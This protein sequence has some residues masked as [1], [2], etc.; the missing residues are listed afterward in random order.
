MGPRSASQDTQPDALLTTS[1]KGWANV[2]KFASSGAFAAAVFVAAVSQTPAQSVA[3]APT[4]TPSPSPSPAGGLQQIGTVT[5]ADR[6][7]EPIGQDSKPTFVVTRANIDATG[8]RTVADAL[9]GVPGVDLFAYGPFG[10]Q[11]N[12]GVRGSSSN[13]TLV[14]V[15]GFPVSDPTTGSVQ[16]GQFSTINV[17]RIEVVESG[18]STLY[19]TSAAGGVINIITTVPRGA[20][21]EASAGSYGDRDFRAGIGTADVGFTYE[22]HVATNDYPYPTFA[23]APDATFPGG[24]RNPSYADMSAGRLN[25]NVPLADGFVIRG[26]ADASATDLGVPGSI[27]YISPAT[28]NTSYNSGLFEIERDFSN[29]RITLSVLGSQT[30]LAYLQPVDAGGEDDVYTGTSGASIKDVISGKLLDAT[31]GMDLTRSSG[32]FSFATSESYSGTL[33]PAYATGAAQSEVA[34]YVQLGASPFAGSRFTAGLRTENNTPAG[35]IL[36]PSFGGIIHSGMLRFSGNVGESFIV[37]TL[38]DLYYPGYS[39]PNL[40]PEKVQTADATVAY[41]GRQGT[42]SAG[43]FDRNGSNFIVFAPPFY[44]PENVQKASTAGVALTATSRPY[45]GMTVSASYTDLYLAIDQGT[46]NRLPQNPVGQTTLTLS[47]PFENTKFE[48]GFNWVVVGSDGDDA[49]N[50]SP[51]ETTYDAYSTLSA[52]V[53]YKLAPQAIVSVRGFNLGNQQYAP[54]FGY[55]APGRTVYV[56]LSTR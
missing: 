6:K 45:H 36:A 32:V 1:R 15:D 41:E 30:R 51:V 20:Y 38:S 39:N 8:A 52:Y 22:R 11:V 44:L 29:Q 53:R 40:L 5:T 18:S 2:L 33:I 7:T 27:D 13:Q 50:V 16:L 48:Y 24:I 14:L 35:P 56:E 25:F 23:Y 28:Q 43:W 19:G 42:V 37:P 31:V 17:S 4:P 49:S 47:H 26:R 3:L 9:A 12:Y 55:P 54:V 46:G 34:E 21:L 10:A